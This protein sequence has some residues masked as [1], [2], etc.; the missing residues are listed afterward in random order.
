MRLWQLV[1]ILWDLKRMQRQRRRL[2]PWPVVPAVPWP[3]VPWPAVLWPVVRVIVEVVVPGVAFD[4]PTVVYA[5]LL[6]LDL[7]MAYEPEHNRP[8]TWVQYNLSA[9]SS[10]ELQGQMALRTNCGQH[11]CCQ[12]RKVLHQWMTKDYIRSSEYDLL[13]PVLTFQVHV[14]VPLPPC[15]EFHH[16]QLVEGFLVVDQIYDLNESEKTVEKKPMDQ[17]LALRLL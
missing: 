7:E 17:P 13:G 9:K 15:G 14:V 2:V 3:A 16:L 10:V 4:T 11:Q 12:T 1:W 5:A 6:L 8:G